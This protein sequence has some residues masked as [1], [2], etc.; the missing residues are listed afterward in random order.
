MLVLIGLLGLAVIYIVKAIVKLS[1]EIKAT[2]KILTRKANWNTAEINLLKFPL[3]KTTATV[4]RSFKKP[5][6]N[7][8]KKGHRNGK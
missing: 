2:N 4:V 8:I 1:K 6:A 3:T 5:K 7:K